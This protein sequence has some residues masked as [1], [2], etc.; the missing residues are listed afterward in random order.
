MVAGR[1]I[2]VVFSCNQ[3]GHGTSSFK[4]QIYLCQLRCSSFSNIQVRL[5]VMDVSRRLESWRWMESRNIRYRCK[6]LHLLFL[7]CI[8]MST[9]NS[10]YREVVVVEERCLQERCLQRFLVSIYRYK[11]K[12]AVPYYTIIW[13]RYMH[14]TNNFLP[15]SYIQWWS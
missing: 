14:N 11:K 15:L 12:Y 6:V 3:S 10:S 8:I 13:F 4:F 9:V 7:H 2:S 5:L 1:T